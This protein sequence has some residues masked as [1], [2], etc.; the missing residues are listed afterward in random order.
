MSTT[1]IVARKP[2]PTYHVTDSLNSLFNRHQ[3]SSSQRLLNFTVVLATGTA[4]LIVRMLLF[5]T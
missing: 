1:A 4:S 3:V 2:M 5:R